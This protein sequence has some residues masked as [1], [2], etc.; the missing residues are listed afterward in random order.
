MVRYILPILI[1]EIE[2]WDQ[3]DAGSLDPVST[4]EMS[5]CIVT[6][7]EYDT[8]LHDVECDYFSAH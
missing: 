2:F 1:A 4:S 3:Q 7:W 5:D 8:E 6:D